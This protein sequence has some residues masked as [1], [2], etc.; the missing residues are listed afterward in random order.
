MGDR[1]RVSSPHYNRRYIYGITPEQWT[2]M[3]A[4]QGNACAICGTAEWGG[5]CNRPS[6]DHDHVTGVFRGILCN[7]CNNGLGRFG[8][9]PARLRA[10]A[11]Y[12]EK[13]L[14]GVPGA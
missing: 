1:W 14:I 13:A 9:D 6:A 7:S 10:A 8:D 11:D 2:A 12:L 3:L 4:G 5:N